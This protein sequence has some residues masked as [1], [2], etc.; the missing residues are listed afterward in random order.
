[1]NPCGRPRWPSHPRRGGARDP[2]ERRR[3]EWLRIRP[4]QGLQRAGEPARDPRFRRRPD[5]RRHARRSDRV[6]HRRP[7]PRPE[8][9]H[10]DLLRRQFRRFDRRL[11]GQHERRR[12]GRLVLLRQRLLL[13]R[14]RRER[15][16]VP[17]DRIWWDYRYWNA[18][19]R[20]PAVVG[21]WPEPFLHGSDGKHYDTVVEC[22]GEDGDCAAVVAALRV[23][24]VEPEVESAP[25]PVEHP[26]E[27]R[28]LVGPWH[29]LRADPAARQLESGPGR[30][31]V[32]ARLVRCGSD[33]RIEPVDSRGQPTGALAQAGLVAAVRQGGDQPTWVVTGTD[34]AE[35]AGLPERVQR[36]DE[37]R[38]AKS[39][40]RRGKRPSD[41]L[42]CVDRVRDVALAQDRILRSRSIASSNG[43]G[44]ATL[45]GVHSQRYSPIISKLRS[46]EKPIIAMV[47]G[48]A[49]G[50]G[51]SCLCL[52]LAY[53][54]RVRQIHSGLCESGP[55]SRF[56]RLLAVAPPG[57]LWPGHG[58]G[59]CGR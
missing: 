24:G 47:N 16:V 23:V 17:G 33:W 14:R 58:T 29:A 48:V 42:H 39:A 6:R 8:R 3:G 56:R 28:V 18:A 57:W 38:A 7:L 31:G 10:R 27:L 43:N 32:Y 53:C 36:R 35:P 2:V 50:A 59:H 51:A 44:A 20:V 40:E 5:G 37:F 54:R 11:R 55:D 19:Y 4:R 13:R 41:S 26:D 52:R 22:L 9:R 12:R 46:M 49:A 30:S 1:M 34:D 45:G 25:R 21:S 15:K